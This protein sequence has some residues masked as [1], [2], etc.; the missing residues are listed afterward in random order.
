MFDEINDIL[1]RTYTSDLL[2]FLFI[3]LG[4]FLGFSSASVCLFLFSSLSLLLPNIYI[5]SVKTTNIFSNE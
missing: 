2:Y 3:D 1:L 4:P 5:S